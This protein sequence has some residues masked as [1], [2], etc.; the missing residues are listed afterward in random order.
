[1]TA[2]LAT[3]TNIVSLPVGVLTPDD[4]RELTDTIRRDT[5]LL[6]DKLARAY[7]GRAWAALGYESWDDYCTNEFADCRLRLPREDRREVVQ[8]LTAQG[9]STRA[10][11]SAIGISDGT[12]RNDLAAQN[13]APQP[14]RGLDN[15]VYRPKPSPTFSRRFNDN[16]S[17]AQSH[18]LRA[19]Q[20]CNDAD[21]PA[22]A[23]AARQHLEGL[24]WMR[25]TLDRII[26][27]L[28][29]KA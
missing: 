17:T 11:A 4:A 26:A 10:I 9:L 29:D 23:A 22:N 3:A 20:M 14:T 5:S 13:C 1:M 21:F 25:D 7:T 15:K 18:L 24:Q 2:A 16:L 6:W 12:V 27:A 28:E 19:A 8:S